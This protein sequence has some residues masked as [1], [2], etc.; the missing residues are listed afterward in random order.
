MSHDPLDRGSDQIVAGASS[1]STGHDHIRARAP[2]RRSARRPRRALVGDALHL[3]TGGAGTLRPPRRRSRAPPASISSRT[4]GSTT[5]ARFRIDL[6]RV[7]ATDDRDLRLPEAC[8]PHR[9]ALGAQRVLGAVDA[10]R[11]WP[12]AS[13]S[14]GSV[15]MSRSRWCHRRRRPAR[16]AAP[17]DEPLGERVRERAERGGAQRQVHRADPRVLDVLPDREQDDQRRQQHDQ[18]R[19]GQPPGIRNG[20]AMSGWLT[21]QRDQGRELEHQ[22]ERVDEHVDHDQRLERSKVKME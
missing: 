16:L 13:V 6:R 17:L 2:R 19:T 4:S 10:S 14:K 8:Y 9:P 1:A 15:L 20:R 22:R 7:E 18:R 11:T 21:P 3:D 5:L 12:I